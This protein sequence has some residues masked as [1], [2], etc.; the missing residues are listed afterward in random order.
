MRYPVELNGGVFPQVSE[1]LG[2]HVNGHSSANDGERLQRD[3]STDIEIQND[4]REDTF[5]SRSDFNAPRNRTQSRTRKRRRKSQRRRKVIWDV[6]ESIDYTPF[7]NAVSLR[8]SGSDRH[9]RHVY[10]FSG[11]TLAMLLATLVAAVLIGITGKVMEIGIDQGVRYRNR[12]LSQLLASNGYKGNAFMVGL[13]VISVGLSATAVQWLAPGAAGSGV[14]L[15][16][17]FL[18]GNE[19]AGLLT[20]VVFVV[21][22]CG[23]VLARVA[24]LTLGP[25]A[26]MVHLGACLSSIVFHAGQ[27]ALYLLLLLCMLSFGI[28]MIF[29]ESLR[30]VYPFF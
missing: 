14:S 3:N 27:R 6:T 9:E 26:P 16:M 5:P 1:N 24:C 17:A 10:G 7:N 23:T 29:A 19:I 30:Y 2:G 12:M 13:S 25:E 20:P 8:R 15:V 28:H 4:T 22:L 18:N 21:K 11:R